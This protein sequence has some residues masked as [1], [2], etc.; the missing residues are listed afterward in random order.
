[1][2]GTGGEV[3]KA[4]LVSYEMRGDQVAIP[5]KIR[6]AIGAEVGDEVFIAP[7]NYAKRKEQT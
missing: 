7:F 6:E 2:I 3:F 1:M 4:A 5:K